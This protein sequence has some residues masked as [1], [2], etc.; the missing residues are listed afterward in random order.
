MIRIATAQLWVHDQ[1][2]A[3]AFYTDKL[4]MEVK[5]DA[6]PPEMQGFRWLTVGP[7]DQDDVS[8]VLMAI[9]GP[10]MIDEL[11][12]GQIDALMAKGF[13]GTVFLTTEDCRA[14]YEVLSSRGVEFTQEPFEAPYGIDAGFRDPSGNSLRLTQVKEYV[15]AS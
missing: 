3:L 13:A 15:P 6:S 7:P 1:D 12:R 4:G 9:P 11:T 2:E 5:S 8:I 10:P 14:D